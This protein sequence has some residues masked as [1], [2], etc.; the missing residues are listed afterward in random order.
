MINIGRMKIDFLNTRIERVLNTIRA[1]DDLSNK[2]PKADKNEQKRSSK[3]FLDSVV[4]KKSRV[5]LENRN[6]FD[7]FLEYYNSYN[8]P[9]YRSKGIL[10]SRGNKV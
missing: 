7:K 3:N 9:K 4:E 1:K 6:K 10:M 2:K 8:D 5:V